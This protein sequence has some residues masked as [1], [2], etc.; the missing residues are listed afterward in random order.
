MIQQINLYQPVMRRERHLLSARTLLEVTGLV[1]F[2]FALSGAYLHWQAGRIEQTLALL[3]DQET[4]LRAQ[5]DRTS[6]AANSPRVTELERAI[7]AVRQRLA[8]TEHL[9]EAMG[10][11]A[12]RH[13]LPLV[14]VFESLAEQVLDGLWLTGIGIDAEE[15][16]RLHGAAWDAG[17]VPEYLELLVGTEMPGS[18][19]LGRVELEQ[20]EG[21]DAPIRFSIGRSRDQG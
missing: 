15:G 13:R 19:G 3:Q 10:E 21:S 18:A 16:L 20:G 2:V 8:G 5:L 1:F 9:L 11:W 17:L 4:A 14:Q 7:E 6:R 12:D